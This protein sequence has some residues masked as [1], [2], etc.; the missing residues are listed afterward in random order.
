EIVLSIPPIKKIE[1]SEE[2]I[3]LDILYEDDYLAIVD[4]PKGM[5]VHPAPGNY[6]GTLVNALLYHFDKLS[7]I[8]GII[9]PGIVH[10]LDKDT[11]G[12]LIIAKTDKIHIKLSQEIEKRKVDRIYWALVERNINENEGTIDTQIARHPVDRMRR[13]V[14]DSKSSRRAI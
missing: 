10:R 7:S 6:S 5:L 2:N 1:I 4:K 12:L 11:S 9:R 3:D 8:G 13:T 14:L